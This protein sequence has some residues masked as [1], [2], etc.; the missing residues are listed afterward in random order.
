MLAA[1]LFN[2]APNSHAPRYSVIA[3]FNRLTARS[4]PKLRAKHVKITCSNHG[5]TAMVRIGTVVAA[6]GGKVLDMSE[7]LGLSKK[8]TCHVWIL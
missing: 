6:E 7:S 8:V 3:L 5:L 2:A 4:P 1:A